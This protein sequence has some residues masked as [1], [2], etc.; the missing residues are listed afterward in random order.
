MILILEAL[1]VYALMLLFVPKLAKRLFKIFG[2][3]IL[4]LVLFYFSVEFQ[5]KTSQALRMNWQ[6]FWVFVITFAPAAFLLVMGGLEW[7]AEKRKSRYL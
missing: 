4:S 1:G 3:I 7:L 6:R 5:E 2:L